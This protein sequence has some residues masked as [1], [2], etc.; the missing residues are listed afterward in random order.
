MVYLRT[1]SSLSMNWTEVIIPIGIQSSGLTNGIHETNISRTLS[2]SIHAEM[3]NGSITLDM[4][5]HE[6]VKTFH[7]Y[8]TRS[9]DHCSCKTT[10]ELLLSFEESGSPSKL[11]YSLGLK[12][13]YPKESNYNYMERLL[14]PEKYQLYEGDEKIESK[15]ILHGLSATCR[16]KSTKEPTP[17]PT[18]KATPTPALASGSTSI[19]HTGGMIWM[20]L[21]SIGLL[22]T[23]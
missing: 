23:L 6:C 4:G 18:D 8:I 13:Y 15:Q 14:L 7:D 22:L 10:I 12:L 11:T 5:A 16:V 19:N 3:H 21:A 1:I 17:T 20:T 2:H 9:A